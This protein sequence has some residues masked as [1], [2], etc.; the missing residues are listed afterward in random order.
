MLVSDKA[1]RVT[2]LGG[3]SPIGSLFILG[4]F[5]YVNYRN[6]LAYFSGKAFVNVHKNVL[7]HILGDFFTGSTGHPE[8][9][10]R[11]FGMSSHM[12]DGLALS[13]VCPAGL[14]DFSWPKHSKLGE[15]IANEHKLYQ[16]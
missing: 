12:Y 9:C 8:G 13:S 6:L 14:P 10:R 3:V 4:G 5:M 7:G 1:V 11:A 15:N 16:T 2:R